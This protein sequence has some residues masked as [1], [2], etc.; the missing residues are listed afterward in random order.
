MNNDNYIINSLD[1]LEESVNALARYRQN[2]GV[3]SSNLGEAIRVLQDNWQNESGSDIQ[4]I[5]LA[6]NDAKK[7]IDEEIIPTIGNYV[8]IINEIVLETKQNQTTIL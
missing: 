5:M 4:S 6:L 3:D 7:S 8:N 1:A 2:L